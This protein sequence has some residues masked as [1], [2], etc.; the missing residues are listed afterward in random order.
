[1]H[2]V[3]AIVI[4]IT[5]DPKYSKNPILIFL[6]VGIRA[7]L[8]MSVATTSKSSSTQTFPTAMTVL[9]MTPAK[10]SLPGSGRICQ[11]RSSGRQCTNCVINVATKYTTEVPVIA[12]TYI[13][14][15][16]F[17]P[18]VPC[19]LVAVR[20]YDARTRL[21]SSS[22]IKPT[23]TPSDSYQVDQKKRSSQTINARGRE[24]VPGADFVLGQLTLRRS[25]R[26]PC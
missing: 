7:S 1:M 11:L 18:F 26:T 6:H 23:N 22:G 17:F 12:Q 21:T 24:A 19:A 25:L 15:G 13:R 10:H 5:N 2:R 3:I 14:I 16:M 9:I 20:Y 8:S 4:A